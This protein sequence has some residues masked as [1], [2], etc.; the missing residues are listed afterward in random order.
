VAFWK[1]YESS[2]SALLKQYIL[3]MPGQGSQI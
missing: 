1:I 2:I 3:Q